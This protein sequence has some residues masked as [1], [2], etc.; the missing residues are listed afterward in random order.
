MVVLAL[1]KLQDVERFSTM[2]FWWRLRADS[3][4]SSKDG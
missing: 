3:D 2:R 4:S 1:L